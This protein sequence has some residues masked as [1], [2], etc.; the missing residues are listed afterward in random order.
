MR[1][2]G[3]LSLIAIAC[4]LCGGSPACAISAISGSSRLAGRTSLDAA[5]KP[6]SDILKDFSGRFSITLSADPILADIPVSAYVTGKSAAEI[7]DLLAD[8]LLA[9]WIR[10]GGGYRLVQ[11]RLGKTIEAEIREKQDWT[12]EERVS[13]IQEGLKI[14]R[15][16]W[17]NAL[18]SLPRGMTSVH[19]PADFHYPNDMQLAT[20]LKS[21]Y[22]RAVF[23]MLLSLPANAWQEAKE[24][25]GAEVPLDA[26]SEA[27]R[28][29][30]AQEIA[31]EAPPHPAFP[32]SKESSWPS[33]EDREKASEALWSG[34]GSLILHLH[35]DR[36]GR[37][38]ALSAQ[39][40]APQV[41]TQIAGWIPIGRGDGVHRFN[42]LIMVPRSGRVSLPNYEHVVPS[43]DTADWAA[44]DPWFAEK[45]GK[46]AWPPT[47]EKTEGGAW[48]YT[49][50]QVL[51][52]TREKV[53]IEYLATR[54]GE[55]LGYSTADF[56]HERG[57]VISGTA[58]AL[59]SK[60]ERVRGVY[61]FRENYWPLKCDVRI[62]ASF[63]ARWTAKLSPDHYLSLD[64]LAAAAAELTPEQKHWWWD[65]HESLPLK[66]Y[67]RLLTSDHERA[68]PLWR[69]FTPEQKRRM[70][71]EH[72]PS[73]SSF[74]LEGGKGISIRELS[75]PA[76]EYI[77]AWLAARRPDAV[78][79]AADVRIGYMHYRVSDGYER[80]RVPI[81][82]LDEKGRPRSAT[83]MFEFFHPKSSDWIEPPK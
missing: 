51:E 60:W 24:P 66:P 81:E 77:E 71:V 45:M 26:F 40:R 39:I 7:M 57:R 2:R 44:S 70:K 6:V 59:D 16:T 43:S 78:S 28:K 33:P 29:A 19:L 13:R 15:Q 67:S 42:H 35:N 11:S 8:L 50:D 56:D 83:C 25:S 34:K 52:K 55:G 62:P 72:D 38:T 76:Q 20:S 10:D 75:K 49:F 5:G 4:W 65:H 23:T 12:L 53:G 32:D 80:E 46:F 79:N 73:G 18:P 30:V 61:L 64:D 37:W 21:E 9:E 69:M 47:P 82:F 48:R 31:G 41:S 14:P 27:A 22:R 74:P 58:G 1:H 36:L 63:F 68:F 3:I 17:E 54:M